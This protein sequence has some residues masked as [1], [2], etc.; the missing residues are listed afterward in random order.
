MA[1]WTMPK[2]QWNRCHCYC[3]ASDVDAPPVPNWQRNGFRFGVSFQI[4]WPPVAVIA[5][6]TGTGL[7]ELDEHCPCC[8]EVGSHDDRSSCN[9][10]PSSWQLFFSLRTHVLSLEFSVSPEEDQLLVR[11]VVCMYTVATVSSFLVLYPFGG[12]R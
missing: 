5:D 7:R 12:I 2:H 6:G 9:Q 10:V 1:I 3:L 8:D 4:C 11:I